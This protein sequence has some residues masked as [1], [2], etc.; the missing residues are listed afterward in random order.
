MKKS[1]LLLLFV[2]CIGLVSC[3]KEVYVPDDT[4]PNQTILKYVQPNQWVLSPNG[5]TYT[6]VIPVSEI[7]PDTFENDDISIMV[8]KGD[9][10]TYEP[11]PAAFNGETYS[12][13]IRPGSVQIDIQTTGDQNLFPNR[14]VGV[15]RVK[16]VLITS[17]L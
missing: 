8:S 4:L 9:N 10:D 2:S 1:L 7:D 15:T 17:S 14:P 16:I 13:L 6:V 11:I 5:T 12:T 3:Q